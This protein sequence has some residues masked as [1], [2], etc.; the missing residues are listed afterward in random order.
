MRHPLYAITLHRPWG[1]AVSVLDKDV[2]NRNWKCPL[3]TCSLLAIHSGKRWNQQGADFI[4]KINPSSQALMPLP[5]KE[6]HPT[7]IIAI[8]QFDGN[9]EKSDSQWFCGTIGWKLSNVLSFSDPIPCNGQQRLWHVPEDLLPEVRRQYRL[10]K[11][12]ARGDRP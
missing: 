10:A 1:W 4:E 12:R 9:V 2:E 7:G 3:P 5:P 8:A 6:D 11:E